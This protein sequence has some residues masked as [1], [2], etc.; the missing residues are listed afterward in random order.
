MGLCWWHSR[1]QRKAAY[2]AVFRPDLPQPSLDD[3]RKIFHKLIFRFDV[4]EI[5]G[6]ANLSEIKLREHVKVIEDLLSNQQIIEGVVRQS[7]IRNK[8]GGYKNGVKNLENE[9]LK[10]KSI[11]DQGDIAYVMLRKKNFSSTHALLLTGYETEPTNSDQKCY[12]F[13]AI[14][15]NNSQ[16]NDQIKYCEGDSQL[17][18]YDWDSVAVYSQKNLE[19]KRIM[20]S[21]HHYCSE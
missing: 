18:K 10:A 19:L 5:P 13:S 17:P 12:T 16:G 14:D 21:A 4:V 15:S 3:F 7:W 1:L 9:F 8:I 2:L 6:F 11:I 20:K